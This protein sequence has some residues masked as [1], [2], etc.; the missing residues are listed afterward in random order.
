[1]NPNL[2][3]RLPLSIHGSFGR[4]V[5]KSTQGHL[6]LVLGS[7][8]LIYYLR[9]KALSYRTNR[10]YPCILTSYNAL[11]KLVARGRSSVL[12]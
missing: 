11:G 5:G 10:L 2:S 4:I 3:K 8:S 1:M 12:T 9:Q 6:P 7:S